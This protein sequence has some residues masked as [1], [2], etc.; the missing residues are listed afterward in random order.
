MPENNSTFF[1]LGEAAWWKIREQ[2]KRT[3]PATVTSTYLATA[4]SQQEKSVQVNILPPLKRM[5]LID[6]K[7]KPTTLAYDWRDDE[8]YAEVC[9]TILEQNYPQEL[10][11]LFSIEDVDQKKLVAWFAKV[12][13]VGD[14]AARMM[15]RFYKLLLR[16]D[17]L[18][19]TGKKDTKLGAVSKGVKKKGIRKTDSESGLKGSEVAKST[20]VDV[21]STQHQP[22]DQIVIGGMPQLHINI[23]LHI[24]P[25]STADQID[26]IF[27]S[28]AK[29]LKDFS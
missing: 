7:G 29:H 23:Q 27:E 26:K 10:R 6:E 11:D 25:E 5:G 1:K 13:K 15:A 28:M 12:G 22:K 2:F 8:K 16:G 20:E 21:K 9:K 19:Q 17:P 14:G 24:S 18:D 3:L 4:L